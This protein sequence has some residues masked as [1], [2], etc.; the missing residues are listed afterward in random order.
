MNLTLDAAL[1]TVHSLRGHRA[2]DIEVVEVVE[3]V[4][5]VEE[6]EEV[7]HRTTV[8]VEEIRALKHRGS[9]V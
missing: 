6:V 5:E 7:A 4:A 1:P 3:V 9:E 2:E 8:A